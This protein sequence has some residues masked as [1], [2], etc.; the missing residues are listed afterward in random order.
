MY[1]GYEAYDPFRTGCNIKR[2]G[3]KLGKRSPSGPHGS[4]GNDGKRGM[5][6][7]DILVEGYLNRHDMPTV[8][9][10]LRVYGE[11]VLMLELSRNAASILA[12]VQS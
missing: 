10:S 8:L 11:L 4:D 9:K 1:L 6:N 12:V 5:N 7:N 3:R 2:V